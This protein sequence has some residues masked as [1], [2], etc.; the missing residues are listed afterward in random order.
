MSAQEVVA[1]AVPVKLGNTAL[2]HWLQFL[3][4]MN[5]C[6]CMY[7][8]FYNDNT[9]FTFT[10]ILWGVWLPS[11]GFISLN[12]SEF[13][14]LKC[15]GVTQ[16]FVSGFLFCCVLS[17]VSFYHTFHDMCDDCADEFDQGTELC[18]V[19]SMNMTLTVTVEQCTSMPEPDVFYC[20]SAIFGIV[21]IVGLCVAYETR[22]IVE[23][24]K[25]KVIVVGHVDV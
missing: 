6:I 16:C 14:S 7:F 5:I 9:S 11:F 13:T 23:R 24:Q 22:N 17:M 25:M 15:F 19:E 18:F 10:Y 2:K 12:A 20:L 8:T 4:G 3:I 21:A 1:T